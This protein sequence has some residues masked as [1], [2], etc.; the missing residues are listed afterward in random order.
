MRGQC[1]LQLYLLPRY[2][3]FENGPYLTKVGQF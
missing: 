3:K 2:S 1:C